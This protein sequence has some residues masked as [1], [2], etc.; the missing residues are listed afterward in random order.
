MSD[1]ILYGGY[2]DEELTY[3][4]PDEYIGSELEQYLPEEQLPETIRVCEYKPMGITWRGLDD[5]VLEHLIETLDDEYGPPGGTDITAD[6]RTAA[7]L[8]VERIRRQYR[9]YQ[10]EM[11]SVEVV[12]VGEWIREH[13]PDWLK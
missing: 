9:V 4:D 5:Y 12:N 6:M 2:D 1:D 3:S 11:V 13:R 10:C 7:F 8:F